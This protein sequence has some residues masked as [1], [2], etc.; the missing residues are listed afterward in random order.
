ME[1]AMGRPTH[2]RQAPRPRP[3]P[4][5]M[6]MRHWSIPC[7][8]CGHLGYVDATLMQIKRWV[9]EEKLVCTACGCI[10]QAF[11]SA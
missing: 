9:A 5:Q 2:K 3:R 8:D 1:L 11:R 10:K 6:L 4:D 7:D